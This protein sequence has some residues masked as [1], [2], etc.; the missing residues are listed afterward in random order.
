MSPLDIL[1]VADPQ[2]LMVKIG[3]YAGCVVACLSTGFYGGCSFKQNQWDAD[4][5]KAEKEARIEEKADIVI[6][7]RSVENMAADKI[8]VAD[9]DKFIKEAVAKAKA[10]KI[11]DIIITHNCPE[12]STNAEIS[13]MESDPRFS[14]NWVWLYDLSI[15]PRET[16]LRGTPYAEIFSI[17]VDEAGAKIRKNNLACIGIQ[18]QLNRL[19]ERI[20]DKQKTFHEPL[21]KF[22]N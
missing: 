19:Q 11:P 14:S 16:E 21:S 5:F 13:K 22:C 9:A 7:H 6:G 1:K 3:I 2:A 4:K 12:V 17:G 8:T 20:C 10:A 15:R 18:D